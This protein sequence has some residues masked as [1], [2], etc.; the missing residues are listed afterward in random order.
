MAAREK[1]SVTVPTDLLWVVKAEQ[2][3][4]GDN[5]SAVITN[6]IRRQLTNEGEEQRIWPAQDS[7]SRDEFDA[8][9]ADVAEIKQ[10]AERANAL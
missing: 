8:L 5:R 9:A 1:I 10:A 7:P 2:K 4:T 6:C 3:A